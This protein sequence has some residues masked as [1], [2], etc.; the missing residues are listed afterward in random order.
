MPPDSVLA[1]PHAIETC[2]GSIR[3]CIW[4]SVCEAGEYR[5]FECWHW[6]MYAPWERY[7]FCPFCSHDW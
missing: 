6:F 1:I 2:Y 3:H 5:C 7:P 4:H